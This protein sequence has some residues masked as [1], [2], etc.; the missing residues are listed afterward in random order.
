MKK[1][2]NL[3]LLIV[4]ATFQFSCSS[5]DNDNEASLNPKSFTTCDIGDFSPTSTKMCFNGTDFALPN[6]TITFAA[7][8]NARVATF[9]WTIESGSIEIINIEEIATDSTL[10]SIATFKFNSDFNGDAVFKVK[11]KDYK[12]SVELTHVVALEET[13]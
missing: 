7:E 3:L 8:F 2:I 5:D 4:I 13:N 12:G 1:S 6:E 11:A 10:K 9:T